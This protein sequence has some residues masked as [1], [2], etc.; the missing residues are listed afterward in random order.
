[1]RTA[2]K[3]VLVLDLDNTLWGGVLAEDGL[4]HTAIEKSSRYRLEM[5][6]QDQGVEAPRHPARHSVQERRA[7]VRRVLLEHPQMVLRADDLLA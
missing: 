4:T 1:M 7:E 3:K 2:R 5:L 6:S